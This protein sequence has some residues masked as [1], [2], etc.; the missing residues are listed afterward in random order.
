MSHTSSPVYSC[1]GEDSRDD[2]N[3]S[4][5][6]HRQCR[7][8]KSA[9]SEDCL[10]VEHDGVNPGKLLKDLQANGDDQRHIDAAIS[11]EDILESF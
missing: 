7:V 1:D 3:A 5:D 6:D 2:V 10:S 11:V 4:Y 9:L 8:G